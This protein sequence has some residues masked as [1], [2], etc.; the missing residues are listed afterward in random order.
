MR[1]RDTTDGGWADDN[2]LPRIA[3]PLDAS[4]PA[5]L[6]TGSADTLVTNVATPVWEAWREQLSRLGGDNPLLHFPSEPRIELSTGHPGGL[7][8]FFSGTPTFLR[9]LVRDDVALHRAKNSA[10]LISNKNVEL[11]AARG[12]DSVH[13]AVGTVE[14]SNRG[15]S[16]CAPMLIR[17]VA[18]HR[19][20]DDVELQLRGS[21]ALNPA[22]ARE[23]H[24]QFGIALDE[25]TFVALTND[26][27]SFRPNGALDR[28]RGLIAHLDDV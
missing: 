14:W 11:A 18:M 4:N 5:G 7:A 20:G 13:L 21:L 6:M 12:I 26:D 9:N 19:R 10:I 15:E 1:V 16:F 24:E 22:L 3:D 25:R 8:R 17:P 2:D 27:G 23:L 28:L